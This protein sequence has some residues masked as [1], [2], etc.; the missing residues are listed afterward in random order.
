MYT[1]KA[2]LNTEARVKRCHRERSLEDLDRNKNEVVTLLLFPGGSEQCLI[3]G[4]FKGRIEREQLSKLRCT[5][6]VAYF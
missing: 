1:C 3:F 4:C 5:K 2:F 6:P